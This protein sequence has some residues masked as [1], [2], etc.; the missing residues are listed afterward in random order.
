MNDAFEL[1]LQERL[2]A[3]ARPVPGEAEALLD[4]FV[5]ARA[6][7]RERGPSAWAMGIVGMAAVV[8]VGVIVTAL[9]VRPEPG[10]VAPSASALPT[11]SFPTIPPAA[12]TAIPAPAGGFVVTV[13]SPVWGMGGMAALLEGTLHDDGTCLRVVSPEGG[14][15][16]VVWPHGFGWFDS[17]EGPVFGS[18]DGRLSVAEGGSIALGGGF[19]GTRGQDLDRPVPPACDDPEAFLMN[20]AVVRPSPTAPTR[21]TPVPTMP[22]AGVALPYPDGCAT[23]GLSERRCAYIERWARGQAGLGLDDPATIE[24]LGDPECPDGAVGC[25]VAR[26]MEFVV[27]VQVTPAGASATDHPVFCGIDGDL[28]LLCTETPRIAV[29]SPTLDGYVDVPCSGE[30]PEGCASP[31]PGPD[32][33]AAAGAVA[34]DVAELRIPVS[35]VGPHSIEVGT[36]VLPNGLLSEASLVLA[37]DR[38]RDFGL[39]ADGVRLVIESLDGGGPFVNAYERGWREGTERIRIRLVFE[40]EWS[41]PGAELVITG[42]AVR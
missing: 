32:P 3:R 18:P 42:I 23:Y 15:S 31:L 20:D 39:A 9:A 2:A 19:I 37:D 28:T 24:L 12:R 8:A 22:P 26:T 10:A 35:D 25:V 5:A 4:A 14:G 11:P 36:A 17:P 27:R 40:L 29:H 41:E 38:P 1:A 7:R 16:V 21:P 30:A 6:T 33:A 13:T 34:L